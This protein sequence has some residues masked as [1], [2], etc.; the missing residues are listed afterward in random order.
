MIKASVPAYGFLEKHL[1][2]KWILYV[3]RLTLTHANQQDSSSNWKKMLGQMAANT[4]IYSI[5]T[6]AT[7]VVML[8]LVYPIFKRMIPAGWAEW[9]TG[10]LTMVLIS[11]LLRAMVMKKNHSE[12]FKALWAESAYNRLPLAFTVL[13]R[14]A[15]A[16]MFV[17]Y[18]VHYLSDFSNAILICIG[19]AVL[20]L[21]ILS[22]TV[23]HRSIR[24]E[25]LF[26][27]NLRSRD[28][29]AQVHGLRRPL[30]EGHL[31]DRD[32]HIADFDVPINS[33]WMGKTLKELAVGQKYGVHISSIMRANRRY[34]I[35]DGESI[36]FPGDKLE[37]IGSDDQLAVFGH[38]L[39]N[40]LFEEDHE[41]EKRE[42]KLRRFVIGKNSPFV[43]R[44]LQES[45]IR[46]KY[47]CMVVGLEEGKEN[48]SQVNP[49]YRFHSGDILW[50]VGEESHLKTL[51]EI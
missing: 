14:L 34:N 44:N 6:A 35:P 40:E 8:T 32:V 3:N 24:L 15:L 37:V 4:L 51:F 19:V 11:P 48:L 47:N 30:Y 50:V 9:V 38:D 31:L 39:A 2:K 26:I 46:D 13:L 29:E 45:G 43:G 33:L 49:S 18:V 41:L 12:E 42:M 16:L 20:A 21:I 36:I 28:I 27:L 17:F 5:V 10:L 23:K 25:R 22:R 7:I 1:P